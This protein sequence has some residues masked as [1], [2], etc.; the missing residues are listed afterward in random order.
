MFGYALIGLGGA[1]GSMARAAV[2]EAVARLT[3]PAFPWGTILINITGSFLIGLVAG[4]TVAHGRAPGLA[5]ARTFLMVGFCGGYT[6]FSSFSLQTLD[7]LRDGR[8]A[9][10]A[11]NVV[12][13][14]LLCL[15]AVAVGH[16]AGASLRAA[17]RQAE[18]AGGPVLAVID[19]PA[20]ATAVLAA[21]GWL[22]AGIGAPT[23]RAL[24]VT[25]ASAPFLPDE[26]V[27]TAERAAEADAEAGRARL[28]AAVAGWSGGGLTETEEHPAAAITAAGARAIVLARPGPHDPPWVAE[29]LHAALFAARAPVL[30]LPPAGPERAIGA[31]VAIGWRAEDPRAAAALDA[32]A[33]L[34]AQARRILLLHVGEAL[35][36]PA[37][38]LGRPARSL[39]VP[40]NGAAAGAALL[41]A[42]ATEGA[43][44]LV[45]GAYSHGPWREA[46]LGGMTRHVLTHASIPLLLRH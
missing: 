37:S 29:A 7:L 24:L 34:L 21:A 15:G 13:S 38:L 27:L 25:P 28:R 6:T 14:V 42:A 8:G 33:P 31:V 41:A 17:P 16:Q 36:L 30:V 4:L 40:R 5:A 45:M 23:L 9:Q 32:A 35:P 20:R 19:R 43:D 3:G 46:L 11:G 10:A 22:R 18:A 26:E 12:L 39:G 1:L 44:L 2:A